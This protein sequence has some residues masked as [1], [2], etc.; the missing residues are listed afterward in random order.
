[1]RA[2]TKSAAPMPIPALAPA[3]RPLDLVDA[4]KELD[5]EVPELVEEM[6]EFDVWLASE[7]VTADPFVVAFSVSCE[8]VPEDKE[9]DLLVSVVDSLAVDEV[10]EVLKV[11]DVLAGFLPKFMPHLTRDSDWSKL[12]GQSVKGGQHA[13]AVPS[14]SLAVESQWLE[15]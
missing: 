8:E 1:M 11:T 7:G 9:D 2:I 10:V 15:L 13:S 6:L 3:E 12:S 14:V 4:A 5:A